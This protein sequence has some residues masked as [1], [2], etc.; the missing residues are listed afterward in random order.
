MSLGQHLFVLIFAFAS[1]FAFGKV[2]WQ[3]RG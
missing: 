2:K 3:R 1:G